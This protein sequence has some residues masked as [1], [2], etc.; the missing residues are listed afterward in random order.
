MVAREI[1]NHEDNNAGNQETDANYGKV[2]Y[3][4]L[5]KSQGHELVD[6]LRGH[7]FTLVDHDIAQQ[8]LSVPWCNRKSFA[9]HRRLGVLA[10]EDAVWTNDAVRN[11]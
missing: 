3:V 6:M 1:G 2:V 4:R 8:D 9:F 5:P 10:V 11:T 7:K